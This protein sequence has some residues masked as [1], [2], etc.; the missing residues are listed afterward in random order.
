VLLAPAGPL[1][2]GHAFFESM[3]LTEYVALIIKSEP[4]LTNKGNH[5]TISV[6]S[7]PL[8]ILHMGLINDAAVCCWLLLAHSRQ[9]MLFLKA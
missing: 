6:A 9:V 4:K 3:K 8:N 7:R 2:S 1:V 5:K